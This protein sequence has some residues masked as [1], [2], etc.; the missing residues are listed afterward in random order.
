VL[1]GY[2]GYYQDANPRNQIAWPVQWFLSGRIVER[3]GEQLFMRDLGGRRTRLV[4]VSDAQF[5][6][7]SDLGATLVFTRDADGTMVL[8][9]PQ[10]YAER[11]P[12]WRVEIVRWP[13]VSAL[14]FCLTPLLAAIAWVARIRLAMPRGF[15]GLKAALLLCPI[16][17]AAPVA[18]LGLSTPTDW[19][20][21]NLPTTVVFVATLALPLLAIAIAIP[22]FVAYRQAASRLLV[23]YA[24]LVGIAAAVASGYLA[25]HGLIALRLWAY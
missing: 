15:W 18:A 16:A 14:V 2:E 1:D 4:P 10:L 13:V 20:V 8:T 23:A 7:E 9:G 25:T 21:R 24:V 17:V 3:D 5:R 22:A 19:G 11:K 12:R 6:R